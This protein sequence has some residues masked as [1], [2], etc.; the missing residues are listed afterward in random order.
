M[1]PDPIAPEMTNN[2]A[3]RRLLFA[4]T[5]N[6]GLLVQQVPPPSAGN[7]EVLVTVRVAAANPAARICQPNPDRKGLLLRNLDANYPLY[8]G[9]DG[10]VTNATGATLNPGENIPLNHIGA[11]YIFNP[12]QTPMAELVEE[13]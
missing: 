7:G 6:G 2:E 5:A 1:T 4:V 3:L 10:L 8:Y 11:L 9:S 13:L 12:T